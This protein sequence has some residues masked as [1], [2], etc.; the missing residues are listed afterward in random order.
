[1]VSVYCDNCRN[2]LGKDRNLTKEEAETIKACRCLSY[3][4]TE[5]HKKITYNDS[6]NIRSRKK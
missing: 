5:Q 1:M 4:N 6:Q 2:L 3:G